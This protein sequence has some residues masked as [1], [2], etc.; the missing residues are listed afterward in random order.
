MTTQLD[1]P[2]MILKVARSGAAVAVC[3]KSCFEGSGIA[4][5]KGLQDAGNLGHST[6]FSKVN[7]AC[8]AKAVSLNRGR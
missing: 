1:N 2:G 3:K 8:T 4:A 5:L 7:P 6:S